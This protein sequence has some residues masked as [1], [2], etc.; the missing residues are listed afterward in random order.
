MN[1]QSKRHIFPPIV[2]SLLLNDLF[3]TNDQPIKIAKRKPWE[4]VKGLSC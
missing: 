1:T 4:V 3:P 2:P